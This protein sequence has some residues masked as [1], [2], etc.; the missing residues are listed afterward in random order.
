MIR[1]LIKHL[2]QTDEVKYIE[3]HNARL[4]ITFRDGSAELWSCLPEA[5]SIYSF[6]LPKDPFAGPPVSLVTE[7]Q[8]NP[9]D[10]DVDI[11]KR[12]FIIKHK[13]WRRANFLSKRLVVHKLIEQ[14]LHEGWTNIIFNFRALMNDLKRSVDI[15][16]TRHI[17]DKTLIV[18]IS[19][20]P[21]RMILEQFTDW[22]DKKYD[23]TMSVRDA[24]SRSDLLL[25]AINKILCK[26]KHT[27]TKH[28]VLWALS[29]LNGVGVRF[30]GP[31]VYR[32]IFKCFNLSGKVIADPYP[33]PAKAFG[34]YL[35]GCTYHGD[36]F[37]KLGEFLHTEFYPI[38]RDSYDCVL[39]DNNFVYEESLLNDFEYWKYRADNIILYVTKDDI[40]KVPKPSKYLK[41][42]TNPVSRDNN[43]LFY[44]E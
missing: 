13:P 16:L 6:E 29:R 37:S 32:T 25:R 4:K 26:R 19:N 30:L 27:V 23:N 41:V 44:Y 7:N 17:D 18:Y 8:I 1:R 3:R 24:W 9:L 40:G 20:P 38:D 28:K 35:E 33:N 14:I 10:Y 42:R 36:T 43:Y 22:A 5:D 12:L 21:G 11:Q 2:Q 34:A 15:N 31:S 39:L